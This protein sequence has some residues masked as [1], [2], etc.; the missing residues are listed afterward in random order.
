[1]F[2]T[3]H[4]IWLAICAVLIPLG[5]VFLRKNKW[6]LSRVL[7][8]CCGLAVLS[9]YI[10]VFSMIHMLP[11]ADS[12]GLYPFLEMGHLP[13]HLCTIQILL[14]FYA[15]FAKPGNVR[16]AVLAFMYPTGA[17]GAFCALLIPSI[18]PSSIDVSQAFTH[19]LAYQYFLWHS[20][21]IIL[22]FYIPLSGEIRLTKKHVFITCGMLMAAAFVSIYLNS[23]LSAASYEAGKPVY[24]DYLVNFFF[25]MQTPIG[26]ALTQKWHWILYYA[27]LHLIG[28]G[29]ITLMFLP[30][31]RRKKR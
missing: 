12:P 26:I 6:P 7:T 8:V 10:K 25:T 20:A 27:V 15:R 16:D 21:L 28:F 19:P 23:A 17:I 14:I 11:A 30:F 31:I 22:G 18:F 5:L 2:T 4:F 24:V 9:E 1:M 3:N 13:F 29:V